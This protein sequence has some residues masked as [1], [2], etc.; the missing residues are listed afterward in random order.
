M[1]SFGGGG[2]DYQVFDSPQ[3]GG[4]SGDFQLISSD[5]NDA[6][7]NDFFKNLLKSQTGGSNNNYQQP[8]SYMTD[9]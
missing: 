7:A 5:N 3:A 1:S 6:S 2:S 8:S 9:N 4:S